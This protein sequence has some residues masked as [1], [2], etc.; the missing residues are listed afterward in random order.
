MRSPRLARLAAV[1][2][3]V[4]LV[5]LVWTTLAPRGFT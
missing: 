1:L 4:A 5:L 2:L 3:R